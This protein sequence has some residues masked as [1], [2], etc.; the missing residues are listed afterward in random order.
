MIRTNICALDLNQDFRLTVLLRDNT[1]LLDLTQDCRIILCQKPAHFAIN[2]I[3]A[4]DLLPSQPENL[5][6]WLVPR[7]PHQILP[8][9]VLDHCS[10]S[11][12]NLQ[13][14]PSICWAHAPSFPGHGQPYS[15]GFPQHCLAYI[16]SF[17]EIHFASAHTCLPHLFLKRPLTHQPK[18]SW[19]PY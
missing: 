19:R 6:T 17:Q 11:S 14:N 18:V 1:C 2:K 7:F 12:T 9:H 4:S 8:S 13:R 16:V 3:D 10:D 5:R 15:A